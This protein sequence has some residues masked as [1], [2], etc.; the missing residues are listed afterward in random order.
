MKVFENMSDNVINFSVCDRMEIGVK[1][2]SIIDHSRGVID[3]IEREEERKRGRKECV[4]EEENVKGMKA[5]ITIYDIR[6]I[7]TVCE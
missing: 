5:V 6:R 4:L 7:F 2:C 1:Y 3:V